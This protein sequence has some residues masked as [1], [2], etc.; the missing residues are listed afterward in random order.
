LLTGCRTAGTAVQLDCPHL[1]RPG[2][3]LGRPKSS[4]LWWVNQRAAESG[5]HSAAGGARAV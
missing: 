4:P 5:H 1:G 2:D 3:A